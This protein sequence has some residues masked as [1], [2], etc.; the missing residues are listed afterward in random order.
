MTRPLPDHVLRR[1]HRARSLAVDAFD[2][3]LSLDALATTAGMSR[4]HF[5]R[6]FQRTFGTTPGR[7]VTRVRLDRARDLLA[8]GASVTEAC[9]SV[10]FSSVASFSSAFSA[11]FGAS[12]RAFQRQVRLVGSVPARLVSTWVPACF[13]AFYAPFAP[14]SNPR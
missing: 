12:P 2:E 14:Q 11:R 9:A 8:R 5:L 6:A 13:A 10:G 3:P 7:F 4:F 1:L